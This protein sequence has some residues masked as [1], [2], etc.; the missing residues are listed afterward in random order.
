MSIRK[1]LSFIRRDFLIH[2][3]YR[4]AFILQL[5]TEV[6]TVTSYY[7][8]S[9]YIGNTPELGGH[10]HDYFAFVLIG[11]ALQNYSS[12]SLRTFSSSIRESQLAGNLEALLSTQTGIPEVI[13]SSA[14]YPF[15]WTSVNVIVYIALGRFLFGV[16]LDSVNWIGA[17][18]VLLLTVFVSSG[19]GILSASFVLVFKRGDPLAWL[20]DSVSFLLAGVL[21][22][23]TVLPAWLSR[24]SVWLPLRYSIEGMRRAVLDQASFA[25]IWSNILPLLLFACAILP[26]SLGAFSLANKWVRISGSMNEY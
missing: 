24:I 2:T 11:L 9:K 10:S 20:L 8:L 21:Y 7:F 13:L 26:V 3:S 12:V 14:L 19:I 16:S 25:E 15:L 5:F 22:P 23:I 17:S 6:L 4:F 18:V 1:A